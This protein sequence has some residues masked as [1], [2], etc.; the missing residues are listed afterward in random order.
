MYYFERSTRYLFSKN[1]KW[2]VSPV[3]FFGKLERSIAL[4]RTVEDWGFKCLFFDKEEEVIIL[5]KKALILKDL[6]RYNSNY[7]SQLVTS[8]KAKIADMI[9]F[10]E[11]IFSALLF[12]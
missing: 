1:R 3:A 11:N 4:V 12:C 10:N 7:T 9:D 2:L 6:I 8:S 5:R